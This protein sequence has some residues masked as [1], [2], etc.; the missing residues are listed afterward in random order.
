M[1]PIK[2]IKRKSSWGE[3]LGEYFRDH[4]KAAFKAAKASMN[5]RT[6]MAA[7]YAAILFSATLL[8]FFFAKLALVPKL[9][10]LDSISLDR[11]QEKA[12]GELAEIAGIAKGF[13]AALIA[14]VI[15]A[16]AL[17]ALLFGLIEGSLIRGFTGS[18][19][20]L[21]RYA[22]LGLVWA[23]AWLAIFFLLIFG[24]RSET[25]LTGLIMLALAFIHFSTTVFCRFSATNRL[26]A[27]REGLAEG[28]RLHHYLLPYISLY[29]IYRLGKYLFDWALILSKAQPGIVLLGTG[30]VLMLLFI[31]F[32]QA[33]QI[34]TLL[35][36][37]QAR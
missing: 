27:I 20:P 10:A 30:M 17:W 7:G 6:L 32:A 35:Q 22:L 23:P 33:F 9:E 8:A 37:K 19:V 25:L 26:R 15:A 1:K 21:K 24:G 29:F 12:E 14:V 13:I 31:G 28:I 34:N 2:T 11:I 3:A 4:G 36:A 16:S 18:D 5:T